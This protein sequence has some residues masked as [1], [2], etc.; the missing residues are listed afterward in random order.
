VFVGRVRDGAAVWIGC[1]QQDG[2]PDSVIIFLEEV[3]F[4]CR[5]DVTGGVLSKVSG[6][7]L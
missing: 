2:E 5:V 7:Q 1:T 4:D 6:C 3:V